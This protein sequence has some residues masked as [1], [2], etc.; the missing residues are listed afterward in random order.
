MNIEIGG[1]YKRIWTNAKQIVLLTDTDRH[2]VYYTVIDTGEECFM[3]YASFVGSY[4][5]IS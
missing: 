4:E 3:S 5:Q 1:L 2:D